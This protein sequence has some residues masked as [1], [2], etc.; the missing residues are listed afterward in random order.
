MRVS[1]SQ[2]SSA[3]SSDLPALAGEYSGL[4]HF[5]ATLVGPPHPRIL[6]AIRGGDGDGRLA[7]V[8]GDENTPST[9]KNE[10]VDDVITVW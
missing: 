4:V 7:C 5:T 6:R 9:L 3:S 8:R 1:R 10:H 2:I